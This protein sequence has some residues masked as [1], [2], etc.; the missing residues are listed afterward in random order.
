QRRGP[1]RHHRHHPGPGGSELAAARLQ[2]L[3]GANIP[4]PATAAQLAASIT[5]L[6]SDDGTNAIGA[7]LESD[8][9]CS[10]L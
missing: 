9:G 1:G 8:G 6:F 5:F 2:P 7:I 4:A 10:A 3:M